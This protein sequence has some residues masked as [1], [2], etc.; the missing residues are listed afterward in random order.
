MK[1]FFLERGLRASDL[2][3]VT[4]DGY[5]DAMDNFR[6]SSVLR[7]LEMGLKEVSKHI[8]DS[9]CRGDLDLKKNVLF[10]KY[11]VLVRKISP[12]C[13]AICDK[14]VMELDGK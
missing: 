9:R 12:F 6:Y 3:D 10:D 1:R 5:F 4:E 8:D 11:L 7:D 2:P 14:V 13:P